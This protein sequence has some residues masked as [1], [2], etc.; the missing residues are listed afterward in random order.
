MEDGKDKRLAIIDQEYE[1][2]VAKIDKLAKKFADDNKKAGTKGL[3]QNGLTSDQQK[4]I[5]LAK[6]YALQE[7]DKATVEMYN[8]E[9]RAMR[10]DLKEYG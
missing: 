7:K 3:N 2:E 6:Q 4:E 10:D 9:A 1:A 5:D 8:E